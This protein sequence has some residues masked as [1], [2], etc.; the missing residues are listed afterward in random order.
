MHY[1]YPMPHFIGL[2]VRHKI[3]HVGSNWVDY[4]SGKVFNREEHLNNMIKIN[5]KQCKKNREIHHIYLIINLDSYA[6]IQPYQQENFPKT[7]V[8]TMFNYQCFANRSMR[9]IESLLV[10]NTFKKWVKILKGIS[11]KGRILKR[12]HYKLPNPSQI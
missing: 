10:H 11:H 8:S 1:S 12:I 2:G 9:M 4:K 3:N 5:C 7:Q 6:L